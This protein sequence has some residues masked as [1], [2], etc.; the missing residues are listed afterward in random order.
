MGGAVC[1][2]LGHMVAYHAARP[3]HD[4][5]RDGESRHLGR[6]NQIEPLT[7]LSEDTRNNAA[8]NTIQHNVHRHFYL[9]PSI[10]ITIQSCC[11]FP[12]STE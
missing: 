12:G 8:E 3:R 1:L 9:S 5:G 10:H 2:L 7:I 4:V 6:R 11:H